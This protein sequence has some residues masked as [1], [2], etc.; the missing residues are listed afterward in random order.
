MLFKSCGFCAAIIL[1]LSIQAP[2]STVLMSYDVTGLGGNVYRY[3]YSIYNNGT[4]GAGVPIL[5]FDV[6]FD[7]A[8]YQ[9]SSLS[10][11]TPSSLQAQWSELLLASAPGV[12][13]LY[14]VMALNGGI[15][16]GSTVSGF[17]VQFAW[18]G[19]GDPGFQPF[20]IYSPDDYVLLQSGDTV[21]TG[22][23]EPSVFCV[24]GISLAYGAW[25]IRRRRV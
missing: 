3:D 18:L 5:L 17:A 16:D 15:P 8:I 24:L 13:A 7:P 2:A 11:V 14:D 23:P 20:K 6:L 21:N 22:V 25:K 12:P 10:I 1:L 9:E 19:Q 4:L